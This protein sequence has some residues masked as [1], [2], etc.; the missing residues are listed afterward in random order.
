LVATTVH[1]GAPSSAN[2]NS[3]VLVEAIDW[4][5]WMGAEIP[6]ARAASATPCSVS[7]RALDD[8]LSRGPIMAHG[9]GSP[10]APERTAAL[11]IH[12]FP[13]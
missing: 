5:K 9:L 12:H 2:R 6:A 1:S 11:T 4:K 8:T 10:V 7:I 3:S 13:I